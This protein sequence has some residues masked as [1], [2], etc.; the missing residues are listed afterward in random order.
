LSDEIFVEI[1]SAWPHPWAT[2]MVGSAEPEASQ[3]VRVV[4]KEEAWTAR[5]MKGALEVFD[6]ENRLVPMEEAIMRPERVA[7][8]YFVNDEFNGGPVCSGT[9]ASGSGGYREFII[10][11]EAMI[12]EWS[13]ATQEIRDRIQS[14]SDRV[15]TFLD[16]MRAF[17]PNGPVSNW[18]GVAY[19]DWSMTTCGERS[20]YHRALAIP[21]ADYFP[22]A[23]SLAMIADTLHADL[24]DPDPLLMKPGE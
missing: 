7:A 8:I 23:A 1:R 16:R 21:S 11:N 19:C 15:A 22:D 3:L 14:D 24:F 9:F 5:M 10:G 4:F 17:P 13:L 20:M 12:A 18:T 2:R 6:L